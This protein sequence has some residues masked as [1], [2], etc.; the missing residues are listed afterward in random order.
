MSRRMRWN[1]EENWHEQS[2][3]SSSGISTGNTIS[4]YFFWVTCVRSARDN[5]AGDKWAK[6]LCFSASVTFANS[7]SLIRSHFQTLFWKIFRTCKS[8][9][10]LSSNAS[11]LFLFLDT[12]FPSTSKTTTQ[13][14]CGKTSNARFSTWAATHASISDKSTRK[15]ELTTARSRFCPAQAATRMSA[16]RAWASRRSQSARL[17]ASREE[18]FSTSLCMRL[19]FITN[20]PGRTPKNTSKS[21]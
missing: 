7:I 20:R 17:V 10:T 12:W 5:G 2:A 4:K 14:S 8:C 16:S 1:G 19:A 6:R 13:L 3:P 15:T 21:R 9:L 11:F 18:P